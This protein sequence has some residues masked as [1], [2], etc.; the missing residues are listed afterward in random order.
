MGEEVLHLDGIEPGREV[1]T[2]MLISTPELW[3]PMQVW[4]TASAVLYDDHDPI[5]VL[6]VYAESELGVSSPWGKDYRRDLVWFYCLSI[7]M[8]MRASSRG[9]HC[10]D[11]KYGVG[12]FAIYSSS[13]SRNKLSNLMRKWSESAGSR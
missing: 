8:A 9:K 2:E 12:W 3:F 11:G 1:V 7:W 5:R 6:P 13:T 4:V 10:G